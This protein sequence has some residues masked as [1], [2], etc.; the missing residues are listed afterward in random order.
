MGSGRIAL[1]A[2]VSCICSAL[3]G[4]ATPSRARRPDARI[5][6]DCTVG[7]ARVYLDDR[8]LGLAGDL[9]QGVPVVSGARR[10][11]VRAEG[12][13]TVYRD[14][15]VPPRGVARVAAPLHAIPE[16]DPGG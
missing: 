11:E 1:V 8:F 4:C 9:A 6:V 10:L 7:T 16:G 13:F 12:Y 14:V 5:A 2:A 15:A 3:G